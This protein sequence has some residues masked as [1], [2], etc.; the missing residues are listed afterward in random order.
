MFAPTPTR[1]VDLETIQKYKKIKYEER[2]DGKLYIHR[3]SMMQE[4]KNTVGR[5]LR[6][7]LLNL[8]FVWKGL[9]TKADVMFI[10]ST[11]PTQGFMAALLKKV[12]RIPI[13]YNLQDIFPDSLVHTGISTKDSLAFRIG[14]WMED[15][16]YRNA[17]KIIVISEDFK[18]NIMAKGVP[19]EKI[20]VI[21]NW[22]DEQ[23]VYHIDRVDNPLFDRYGLD[24]SKFY[25]AY[26]G[27][28][29]LTQNMELLVKAAEE[30]KAHEDIGFIIV[31]D[32]AYKDELLKR[33]E[34]KQLKNITLLPFQPY[35]EIAN[36]FSLGDVGLII[37]KPGVGTNSV[38]SKTWS[39]MAAQTPILTSF[40]LDS[41]LC[42]LVQDNQCGV[43]VETDN[44]DA[45][46]A[47]LMELKMNRQKCDTY[48]RNGRRYIDENL[49]RTIGTRQYIS[50]MEAVTN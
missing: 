30:L 16:T 32:G 3:F 10:D 27:N 25:V 44:A 42:R 45:L 38:P 17:D 47:E 43:S 41:E 21:Y 39:Y 48:G 26:S 33:I 11:P 50:V 35:E 31:G 36:V 4:G 37:S 34:E 12:K 1:G 19:E 2:C 5:A 8:V 49:T 14:R 22:V 13:V 7:I 6:Y 15:I 24:R 18:A 23:A 29:G 20:E 9:W 40:D 46:V 28:I